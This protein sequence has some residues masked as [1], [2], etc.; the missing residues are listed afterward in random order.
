MRS[1][2]TEI[3]ETGKTRDTAD[4]A[5]SSSSRSSEGAPKAALNETPVFGLPSRPWKR[6]SGNDVSLHQGMLCGELT[7]K[8]KSNVPTADVKREAPDEC[9]A[10][11]GNTEL[12]A[13]DVKPGQHRSDC[14][15]PGA[16][17]LR[18]IC[19]RRE[20]Q[21]GVITREKGQGR[22]GWR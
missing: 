9:A 17:V 21:R 4:A 8:V 15:L 13:M 5:E 19:N 18:L 16:K 22:P 10:D 1:Y 14:Y 11:T 7:F 2:L 6:R 12:V 20:L 3:Q